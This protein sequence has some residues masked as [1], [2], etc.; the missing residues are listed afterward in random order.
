[1]VVI[2]WSLDLLLPMQSVH[3]TTNI[4]IS[5]PAHALDITLCDQVNQ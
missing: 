5:N 1:M 2:V 3:I 4:V